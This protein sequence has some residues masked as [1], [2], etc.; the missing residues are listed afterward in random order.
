VVIF[1]ENTRVCNYVLHAES[2]TM[3]IY[4][5]VLIKKSYRT[6]IKVRS[7]ALPRP[8]YFY[9]TFTIPKCEPL[10]VLFSHDKARMNLH[11]AA[12]LPVY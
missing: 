10:T 8:V 12:V 1:T 5:T 3:R 11:L 6:L 7:A 2:T 9:R 4:F